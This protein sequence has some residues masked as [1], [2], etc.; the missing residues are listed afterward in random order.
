MWYSS[1]S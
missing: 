1:L